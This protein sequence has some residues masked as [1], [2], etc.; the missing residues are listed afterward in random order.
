M[1]LEIALAFRADELRIIPFVLFDAVVLA[2]PQLNF[3]VSIVPTKS[4]NEV[5][6]INVS[7]ESF[8]RGHLRQD[9]DGLSV[10]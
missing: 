4:V 2:R 5:I 3:V 7:K 8:L 1:E 10:V 9:F 6:V